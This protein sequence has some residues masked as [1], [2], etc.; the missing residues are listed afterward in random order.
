MPSKTTNEPRTYPQGFADQVRV[1][2]PS[3]VTGGEGMPSVNVLDSPQEAFYNL[4][5][6]TWPEAHLVPCIRYLR[7]NKHLNPP[8]AWLDVF[9]EPFEILHRRGL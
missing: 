3:L 7:G 9:P 4:P 8:K 6:K 1:L 2:H 5:F